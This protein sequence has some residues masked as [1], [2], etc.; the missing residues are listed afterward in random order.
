MLMEILA[1]GQD[2][3]ISYL[4]LYF[5]E[6]A[7]IIRFLLLSRFIYRAYSKYSIVFDILNS[8]FVR[9]DLVSYRSR[10]PSY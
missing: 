5:D 6:I 1:I 4:N 7:E 2:C 9:G 8:H 10:N 3:L